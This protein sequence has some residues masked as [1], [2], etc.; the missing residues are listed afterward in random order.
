MPNNYFRFKE[1]IIHQD[2]CSMKVCT[3][4]GIFGAW[5]ANCQ[6]PVANC[7]DIGTGTGVLSLMFAQKN[8]NAI[9]DAIEIEENA[10]DQAKENFL[11]SKWSDRLNIF[12]TDAKD[13][14]S[15]KKYDLIIS[16]PPFYE[17][18][19][20]STEKIRTLQNMMKG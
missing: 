8:A 12:H 17:N 7:L 5:V 19:L 10:F 4:A 16:N 9:I 2:K 6:L 1:F 13:F 15:E 11:I 18:E 14:V 20:Q 3:D